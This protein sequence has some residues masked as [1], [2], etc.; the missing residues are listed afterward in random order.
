MDVA[1]SSLNVLWLLGAMVAT[2]A[3]GS[4]VRVGWLFTTHSEK[5]TAFLARLRT[6]WV[7]TLLFV[8][9]VLLG[10]TAAV[11]LFGVAS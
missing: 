11:V 5:T 7:L 3:A 8:A 2:L 9:A 10:R 4:A 1:M 6:W